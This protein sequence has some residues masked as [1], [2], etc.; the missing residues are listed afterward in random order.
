MEGNVEACLWTLVGLLPIGKIA[1]ALADV[2]KLLPKV[3]KFLDKIND[4]RKK[5]D[6]LIATA[7]SKMKKAAC[8][9]TPK[10]NSF[11]PGTQVLLADGT[12]RAIEELRIGDQVLA[13]DPVTGTTVA[14]P[15]TDTI[16]G[17]G[18]KELVDITVDTDGARGTDTA[19]I[20]ATGNHPFWVPKLSEWVDAANLSAGQ[21]LRT[22]A[23][24]TVQIA[25][26]RH[27][28]AQA[29]VHNLTVA[30]IHTYY[31]VAG[32]ASVLV[33]NAG[34]DA[35]S[36]T[37]PKRLSEHFQDHGAEMGI[38]SEREYLEAAMDL[39]CTCDGYRPGVLHKRN[40]TTGKS[41]FYDPESRE[42]AVTYPN[43]IDTY[44]RLDGGIDS[45][46]GMPGDPVNF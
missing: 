42:F 8:P 17:F 28:V 33:H 20:T 11:L 45:F 13:T 41:Y 25:A 38:E 23:G 18:D 12:R 39:A 40:S 31:V 36:W 6:D 26:V 44:Y 7:K 32:T 21:R 14:K 9:F 29:R 19:S 27:S 34:C 1:G 3:A 30:D 16:T 46:K 35:D 22:S 15:V 5:V 37:S 10:K 43:G 24:T 2:A 4:A